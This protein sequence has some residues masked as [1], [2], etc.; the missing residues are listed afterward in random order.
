M[1]TEPVGD[2]I[3]GVAAGQMIEFGRFSL[4]RFLRGAQQSLPVFGL[5]DFPQPAKLLF[6]A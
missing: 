6:Q 3:L 1:I 4:R 2:G 5:E